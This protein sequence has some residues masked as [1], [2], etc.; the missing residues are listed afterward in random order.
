M[1]TGA[2]MAVLMVVECGLVCAILA[3]LAV[4]LK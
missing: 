2:G 4:L 1:R 3:T